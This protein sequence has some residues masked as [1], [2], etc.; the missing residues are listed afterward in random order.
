M[1]LPF[2]DN[3]EQAAHIMTT[4]DSLRGSFEKYPYR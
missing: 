2:I 4:L 3:R 1:P